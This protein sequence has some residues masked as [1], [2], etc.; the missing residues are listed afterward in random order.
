MRPVQSPRPVVTAFDLGALSFFFTLLV[1]AAQTV[2]VGK[3][4]DLEANVEYGL[5]LLD[6][7]QDPVWFYI[8]AT[9]PANLDATSGLIL[10]PQ[11][12]HLFELD[13]IPHS[14]FKLDA[15]SRLFV[16]SVAG[17]TTLMI[18]EEEVKKR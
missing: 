12:E 8:G 2:D 14:M 4:I 9:A 6:E 7:D 17:P 1:P 16:R 11:S 13:V 5:S 15:G 10:D 3:Y 18:A